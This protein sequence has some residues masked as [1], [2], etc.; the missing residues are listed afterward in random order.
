MQSRLG[1]QIKKTHENK[2]NEKIPQ[3]YS[4]TKNDGRCHNL[5]PLTDWVEISSV[6]WIPM[7]KAALSLSMIF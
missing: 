7:E 5:Y 2:G 3:K 6:N 4:T 1:Y